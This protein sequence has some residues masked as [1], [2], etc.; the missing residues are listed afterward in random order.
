MKHIKL[1]EQFLNEIGDMSAGYYNVT[2]PLFDAG[3]RRYCKYKFE[4]KSGLKY[5]VVFYDKRSD[6]EVWF[7]T[8]GDDDKKVPMHTTTDKGEL[9]KVM[10]TTFGIINHY[11]TAKGAGVPYGMDPELTP[12]QIHS[13]DNN[14]MTINPTK[15]KKRRGRGYGKDIESD[16][17]REK[18]YM[19][20]L[21][22]Q[23]YKPKLAG[24]TIFID[25]KKYM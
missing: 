5:D 7:E 13:P 21:K 4:T 22:K 15:E 6:V 1:F 11:L 25:L 9:Y 16:K 18:L 17:R 14:L 24:D 12:K 3:G 20:Y 10:A 8:F 19:T 2:G 23:G